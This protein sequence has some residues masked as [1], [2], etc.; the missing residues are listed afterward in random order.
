M[1]ACLPVMAASSHRN[2]A[3]VSRVGGRGWRVQDLPVEKDQ[4]VQ[5][6]P[7]GGGRPLARGG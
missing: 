3:G 7:R 1:R 6:L 4:G 2:S 5:G